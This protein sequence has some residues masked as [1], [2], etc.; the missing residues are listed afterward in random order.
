MVSEGAQKTAGRVLSLLRAVGTMLA[1]AAVV[2][3][4]WAAALGAWARLVAP[5]SA[6]ESSWYVL[7]LH[8]WGDALPNRM[9]LVVAVI[10]VV[11]IAAMAY[12]VWRGHT[13]RDLAATPAGAA[14]VAALLVIAYITQGIPAF[15]RMAMDNAPVTA[16]L[17]AGMA[18]WWLCLAGAA[19]TF[20]AARAFPRL[21]RG[22]VKLLAVGAAIAVVV[23]AVVTVGALRA[24]DDGRFVDATTAAASDVPAMPGALGQRT[25]TVSAPDAFTDKDV[26][27]YDIAAAGA[28]FAVYQK[29]R[30]TAYGADGKERWYYSRTGPGEVRVNG[31]RVVDDGAT[32]LAFID[33]GLVGLDAVTGDRLWTSG[34]PDLLEAARGRYRFATGPLVV[35]WNDEQMWTRY[36]SRTGRP[37][38]NVRAP[39]PDCGIVEPTVTSSGVVSAVQCRDGKV[40]LTVLDPQTGE[41]G[42]DT[43]LFESHIDPAA[44]IEQRYLKLGVSVGNRVGV[45]V[46]AV[47]PGAPAGAMYANI[48]DR[49]VSTLPPRGR[50]SESSGL[51]DDFLVWYLEDVSTRLTLFG[52]DGRE[53]CGLPGDIEPVRSNVPSQPVDQPAY[54]TASGSLVVADRGPR[55]GAASLRTFDAKSCAQTAAVPVKS[56]EGFVP[57]PGAVLVL[58]RDGQTLQIDGYTD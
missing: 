52:P 3:L 14:G 42:W 15:Y 48:V 31:M 54:F 17:P 33:A 49:T 8:R 24:G 22:A 6:G 39:H 21:E 7:G 53:R 55:G 47:G 20:L 2:L 44:P 5:R 27:L 25:F 57:A 9:A 45:F 32:V 18:S 35:G 41:I 11:L 43:T 16:A 58:W 26:P 50:P 19:A 30:I 51:N 37:M 40:W 1:G 36:D 12:G 28:G 23:A 56:V 29:G 4:V 13:G 46:S 34:D 38:W 10:A